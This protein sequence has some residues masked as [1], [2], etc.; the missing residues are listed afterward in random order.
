MSSD[1]LYPSSYPPPQQPQQPY[2]PPQSSYPPAQAPQ[3]SYPPAQQAPQPQSPYSPGQMPPSSSYP[4]NYGQTKPKGNGGKIALIIIVVVLAL[5]TIS[6][7]VLFYLRNTA[8]DLANKDIAD[9]SSQI[10]SLNSTVASD[11]SKISD[12]TSKN[13]T[14]TQNLADSEQ[15]ANE[16]S[17]KV[18]K[19]ICANTSQYSFNFSSSDTITS[20]LR[21]Y[22]AQTQGT[23]KFSLW[24]YFWPDM[25]T[26]ELLIWNTSDEMFA[27]EI[28][29]AYD[30]KT[31][32]NKIYNVLDECFMDL[33]Q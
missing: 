4:Y 27:Y 31:G 21:S 33:G 13:K 7:W 11:N 30:S 2:Q 14:L 23:V 20:S 29:F 8:L 9:K 28:T 16:L 17:A 6:G 32:E 25:D 26:A 19:M 24:T 18:D 12:L 3:S 1:P 22:V 15:K 10:D 5:A